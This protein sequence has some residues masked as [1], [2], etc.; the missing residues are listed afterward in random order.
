[1]VAPTFAVRSAIEDVG[2]GLVLLT[3]MREKWRLNLA[4]FAIDFADL[5]R[6]NAPMNCG[7]PRTV[8]KGVGTT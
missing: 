1:M 7:T 8:G 3:K 4:V 5:K 6:Y 2:E